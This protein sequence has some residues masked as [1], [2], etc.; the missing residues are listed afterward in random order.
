MGL[1]DAGLVQVSIKYSLA[2][3][4]KLVEIIT[5][6]PEEHRAALLPQYAPHAGL[7]AR[8]DV[9]C[10]VLPFHTP[11]LASGINS[12]VLCRLGSRPSRCG[13]RRA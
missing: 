9:F 6:V 4:P 5:A 12:S 3:A 8:Q 10:S 1:A 11:D 2:K 13:Q 7:G